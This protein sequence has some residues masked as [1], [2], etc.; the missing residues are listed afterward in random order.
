MRRS[1]GQKK[2]AVYLLNQMVNLAIKKRI[3]VAASLAVSGCAAPL[4]QTPKPEKTIQFLLVNDVYIGEMMPNG[5][6]GVARLAT[7]KRQLAA[8][9][10]V[11]MVLAG[12][13]LFPSLLSKWYKGSQ[14]VE[15]FNAAALDFATYGNH[16]FDDSRQ[17]LVNRIAQSRFKWT[18]ANCM[19]AEGAPIPG[20]SPWDTVTISG[21]KFGLVGITLVQGYPRWIKCGNA[22]SALHATVPKLKAAGAEFI[23]GLTH[24]NRW[25]DS[26]FLAHE[27]A[28]DF[29][30]GGHEHTP[31][32]VEMGERFVVK[33][34][35]NAQSAQ[36]VTLV[37]RNGK[38][39]RSH[40][41]IKLDASIPSDSAVAALVAAW[42]DTLEKRLG[43][44][45]I[46]A[47]SSVPLDVTNTPLRRMET[48]FGNLVADA[49]RTGTGADVAVTIGG[50]MRYDDDIP[51]GPITNREI[52]SIFLYPDETRIATFVVSGSRLR[53]MLE[54]SVSRG[55]G[56]F[57]GYLQVSGVTFDWDS[58]RAVG[59]RITG[60]IRRTDGTAIKP[61]DAVKLSVNAYTACDS[62]DGY[63]I[64]ESA[65]ACKS[66]DAGPRAAQLVIDYLRAA[67][68]VTLPPLGRVRRIR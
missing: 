53:E 5:L 34:D 17:T 7:L 42:Q 15:Y 56:T 65:E 50:A 19:S 47:T 35:R 63:L 18:N 6:G 55:G 20:V 59:S 39:T 22:D 38:W 29:I 37:Q 23:I 40:R 33:A 16:E 21:V 9:G 58:T 60:D 48:P 24:A 8:R 3:L 66:R 25:E 10:S 27:P 67:K 46:I 61:D 26:A 28:I 62:G 64:P 45:V 30:L 41:L 32:V 43:P 44:E 54:H 52:E 2:F 4:M 31:Q 57:G 13:F 1:G 49:I 51:A 14:V 68:T 11:T 12:D 36:L